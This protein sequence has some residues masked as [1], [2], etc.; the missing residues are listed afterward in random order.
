[1]KVLI[2]AS[3]VALALAR[4]V[5]Q[6]LPDSHPVKYYP[7]CREQHQQHFKPTNKAESQQHFLFTSKEIFYVH[8][9][10]QWS[11]IGPQIWVK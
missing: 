5:R 4:E 2:L 11:P 10:F 7:T 3:L 6:S 8:P 1:M 9:L